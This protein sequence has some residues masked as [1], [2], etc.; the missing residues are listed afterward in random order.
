[1][2]EGQEDSFVVWVR[3]VSIALLASQKR[4]HTH[5]HTHT[6]L[7]RYTKFESLRPW[8]YFSVQKSIIL[9][10][11][12]PPFVTAKLKLMAA[13]EKTSSIDDP[14]ITS[15]PSFLQKN[16]C[17]WEKKK[18]HSECP[19]FGFQEPVKRPA[20]MSLWKTP[21]A[22]TW[23][24]CCCFCEM[25]GGDVL[26]CSTHTFKTTQTKVKVA[27]FLVSFFLKST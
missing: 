24:L 21:R 10:L 8:V 15:L 20:R 19:F 25:D 1:M 26:L 23:L 27:F 4:V 13:N 12:D 7:F 18:T 14:S 3:F 9:F 6:M 16:D 11:I 5:P 2:Y 17:E 22:P